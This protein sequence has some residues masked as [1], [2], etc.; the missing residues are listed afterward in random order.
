M[1]V[2]FGWAI[3]DALWAPIEFKD[4]KEFEPIVDYKDSDDGE[5]LAWERTDDTSMTLCL[6]QSLIN[7]KWFDIVDQL[8]LYLKWFEEGY[9]SLKT[10]PLWI[11]NQTADQI[12]FYKMYKRW[13]LVRKHWEDDFSWLKMDWN[14]SLMRIGPIPLA[15]LWNPELAIHYA[16]ESSKSTHHTDIC[17]DA[18]K[19]Y[20]WLIIWAMDWVDK[21]ELLKA[22]YSPVNSYREEHKI[23]EELISV[24]EWS[25][26]TKNK[27]ELIADWYVVNSLEVALWWFYNFDSFEEWLINV[28]NLW[29]DSDTNWCIYWFLAWAYYGYENIPSRWKS[30]IVKKELIKDITVKLYEIGNK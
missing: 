12:N 21:N 13:E 7:K 28:V 26:K 14:W 9:M 11:W 5:I 18:C 30:T 23:T 17:I 27:N 3:G 22:Y 10:Y 20:T 29:Y 24:V 2:M 16:W 15:Y 25:Y 1:G 6:A 19:Y 4:P 8:E